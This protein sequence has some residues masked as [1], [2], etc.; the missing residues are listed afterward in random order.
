MGVK[1]KA[2]RIERILRKENRI[3]PYEPDPKEHPRH[4]LRSPGKT[5]RQRISMESK[6]SLA[7]RKKAPA[8]LYTHTSISIPDP[9]APFGVRH[10]KRVPREAVAGAAAKTAEELRDGKT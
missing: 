5:F 6:S 7:A 2:R 10:F 1:L 4:G 9:T 3:Q 8:S